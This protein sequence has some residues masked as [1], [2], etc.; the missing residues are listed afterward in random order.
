MII[1]PNLKN[2]DVAREFNEL[3]NATSEAAAYHIWSLN[4]GNGIDKAPNGAESKLFQTLLEHYGGDRTKAIQAK[5]KTYGMSFLNWFGDWT[6]ED[7]K[8]VSKVVD[9][10][11]EPLVVY[12]IDT[13]DFTVFDKS[14]LETTRLDFFGRGFYF[15]NDLEAV[16]IYY[17]EP[18]R[19]PRSFFLNMRDFDVY[20]YQEPNLEGD[21]SKDRVITFE[22]ADDN[23]LREFIVRDPNQIKSIDNQG[24]TPYEGTF[25]TQNDD[26]MFHKVNSI[27]S[28]S[29]LTLIDYYVDTIVRPQ[30]KNYAST[31][32]MLRTFANNGKNRFFDYDN[33]TEY[34][35][36]ENV[37]S[38]KNEIR[39]LFKDYGIPDFMYNIKQLRLPDGSIKVYVDVEADG[40]RIIDG[41]SKN[42]VD[43]VQNLSD[44]EINSQLRLIQQEYA[45]GKSGDDILYYINPRNAEQIKQRIK[46]SLIEQYQFYEDLYQSGISYLES[47]PNERENNLFVKTALNWFKKVPLSDDQ[48]SELLPI[49]QSARSKSIDIQIFK[50]PLNLINWHIDNNRDN[51]TESDPIDA[52]TYQG[53]TFNKEVILDDNT[54]IQIYDVQDSDIGQL[55]ICKMLYDTNPAINGKKL[56]FSPWCLSTF[57]APNGVVKVTDSAKNFWQ[58]Y[59][60]GKRQIAMFNGFPVAF[61]STEY[62]DGND[63]W[64]DFNDHVGYNRIENISIESR[65]SILKNTS[66]RN[67]NNTSYWFGGEYV[68]FPQNEDLQFRDRNLDYT[69]FTLN[70]KFNCLVFNS[71]K[72]H[73]EI[74]NTVANSGSAQAS[75]RLKLDNL[76]IPE[77]ISRDGRNTRD[78]L[79]RAIQSFIDDY[80][81]SYIDW[82]NDLIEYP[83]INQA[84]VEIQHLYKDLYDKL[85]QENPDWLYKNG[86]INTKEVGQLKIKFD[87]A[88]DNL[89][90]ELNNYFMFN[91]NGKR[92]I[93]NIKKET[94]RPSSNRKNNYNADYNRNEVNIPNNANPAYAGGD[95]VNEA[96][97][98]VYEETILPKLYQDGILN[99][100]NKHLEKHLSKILKKFHFEMIDE[101]II[102]QVWGDDKLGAFDFLQKIIYLAKAED[103]NSIVFPEEF[104]HAFIK[105]MGSVYHRVENRDKWPE[106]KVY[107]QLRDLI[108]KTDFYLQVYNEYSG[109]Y[110]FA[111]QLPNT[112]AIKEE[113]LGKALAAVLS[114]KAETFKE[115]TFFQKLKEWFFRIIDKFKSKVEQVESEE[116]IDLIEELNKIADSILDGS[117]FKKYLKKVDSRGYKK[118][119]Y[120]DTIK[121]AKKIDGGKA[122][123]IAKFFTEIGGI[124][125]GSISYRLQGTVYR[126]SLEALHD[127]DI[128]FSP[129][130]FSGNYHHYN[131]SEEILNTVLAEPIIDTIKAR[132]PDFNVIGAFYANDKVVVNSMICEDYSLYER[133]CNMSGNFNSRME[134]FTEEE[135]KKMYLV[136][137]FF[138]PDDKAFENAIRDEENDLLLTN[139]T[140]PFREKLKFGR[141]K[142]LYDY[143]MFKPYSRIYPDA[144]KRAKEQ[145]I[146]NSL[147]GQLRRLGEELMRKCNQ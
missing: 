113:A 147:K 128:A 27:N 89:F 47:L 35:K 32:A 123:N 135:Q 37:K 145:Q 25:S 67:T 63:Q 26:I 116:K 105:M 122:Y 56:N 131:T 130:S 104:S 108:E 14:K 62:S 65:S 45:V 72:F 141:A 18:N 103:R 6:Q 126:K 24:P 43:Y 51:I 125:S 44:D 34:Y 12:R 139:Y 77:L 53:V 76:L 4:N 120:K 121:L 1:C 144:Y 59:N 15:S 132:Y 40:Q 119:N 87:D 127:L 36:F 101:D 16:N 73:L 95:P 106:T 19:E 117:Y 5:A 48:L 66:I 86:L 115:K 9:E 109:Q 8:N 90:Y 20:D 140:V 7:K 57:T 78:V 60:R 3:K 80:G 146:D 10:N 61:N 75:F 21:M 134:H 42:I 129:D 84:L 94:V 138:N 33:D 99:P 112:V 11:G 2:P 137:I 38:R 81:P 114:K 41:L 136:D 98:T 17:K 29:K 133:F 69:I 107:S 22:S 74:I 93:E 96:I 97:A 92:V 39:K 83:S 52:S 91:E 64:W 23:F 58:H 111:N 55:S 118:V 13:S 85:N 50:T 110:L 54:A 88:F 49:F 142:D 124:I 28:H 30:I 100:V 68:Y 70:S 71:D 143:Q 46:D 82:V 102:K 79:Q 31:L